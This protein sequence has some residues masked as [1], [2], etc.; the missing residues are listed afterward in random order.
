MALFDLVKSHLDTA[1]Q[2]G[3][4]HYFQV[5]V[6][7]EQTGVFFIFFLVGNF[8]NHRVGIYH[9]AAAL[10]NAFSKNIGFLSGLPTIGRDMVT[11]LPKRLQTN[12]SSV[13]IYNL[14][15]PAFIKQPNYHL[16]SN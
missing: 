12:F 1:A 2:L 10:V 16:V 15:Q 14:L 9:A 6:L 8:F 7:Q 11:F 13:Y 4:D 5:F 3:Q